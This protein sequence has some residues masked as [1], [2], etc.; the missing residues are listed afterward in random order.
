MYYCSWK[1]RI[2]KKENDE[3][4]LR[5]QQALEAMCSQPEGEDITQFLPPEK[6]EAI[7]AHDLW[8]PVCSVA[9]KNYESLYDSTNAMHDYLDRENQVYIRG[10]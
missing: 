7:K 5:L 2:P 10:E 6:K 3:G 9:D 8:V 4:S 1:I